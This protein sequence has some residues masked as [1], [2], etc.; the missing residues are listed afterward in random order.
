VAAAS[1]P[2]QETLTV[3]LFSPAT[4]SSRSSPALSQ[5]M[6]QPAQCTPSI[7]HIMCF[8]CDDRRRGK[9]SRQRLKQP[10]L[11]VGLQTTPVIETTTAQQAVGASMRIK[12]SS[13]ARHPVETLRLTTQN[14]NLLRNEERALT[15]MP[16]RAPPSA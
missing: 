12:L 15:M 8:M 2:I 14:D 13:C 7:N 16:A 4:H 9:G 6:I 3:I 11:E 10:I 1:S 5:L